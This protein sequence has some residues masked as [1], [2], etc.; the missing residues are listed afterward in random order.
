[1]R[2]VCD[3]VLKLFN[4]YSRI[5]RY[6]SRL[7]NAEK[8]QQKA[9]CVLLSFR[10]TCLLWVACRLKLWF[11]ISI[12]GCANLLLILWVYLGKFCSSLVL[13]QDGSPLL[14]RVQSQEDSTGNL[15]NW[16][17]PTHEGAFTDAV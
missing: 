2:G 1:M 16:F 14:T 5:S 6:C 12:V 10:L 11:G 17:S 8:G 15:L 3:I 4:C 9:L 13:C 7:Y